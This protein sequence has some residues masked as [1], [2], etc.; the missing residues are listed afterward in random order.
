M[1]IQF[2][3]VTFYYNKKTKAA[4]KNI[5]LDINEK[6]D[7]ISIIGKIGSGKSTLV[8]L[9][10]GLLI[11]SEGYLNIFGHKIDKKT[12]P[13]NLISLKQKIGLV[14]QFPEY[15]LFENTVLKDV[16]FGPKNFN[17]NDN[18]AKRKAIQ[19][20]KQVGIHEYLFEQSP[21]KLSEGQQRKVAIAGVLAIEPSILILDEPTRGLDVNSQKEIMTILKNKNQKERNTIMFIT[22]DMDLVAEYANKILFLDRGEIFFFDLK[23]IF[24]MKYKL[25][26]FGLSEPQSFKILKFLNKKL[27]IPFEPKF[28][29]EELLQ[30]LKKIYKGYTKTNGDG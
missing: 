5:N 4:L 11:P 13:Q 22:H 14:F 9:M 7:F 16:M 8:Q 24:F 25:S 26:E 12:S 20:L 17:K 1:A 30:Y 10:N 2:R 28:S 6:D 18:E 27:G 3:D 23:K 29:Y 21:F 19:V 15:Q